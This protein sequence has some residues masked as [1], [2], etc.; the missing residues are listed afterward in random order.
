MHQVESTKQTLPFMRISCSSW[1]ENRRGNAE[2]KMNALLTIIAV[3]VW[4]II[5]GHII[6]GFFALL[7]MP[8]FKAVDDRHYHASSKTWCNKACL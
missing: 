1:Q 6:D 5:W 3:G 2:A 8:K 7:D 4:S